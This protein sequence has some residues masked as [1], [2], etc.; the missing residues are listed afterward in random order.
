MTHLTPTS[1]E[2]EYA[3]AENGFLDLFTFIQ[4]Q[5]KPD[6]STRTTMPGTFPDSDIPPNTFNANGQH[7]LLQEQNAMPSTLSGAGV[8]RLGA[9]PHTEFSAAQNFRHIL[10][11]AKVRLNS[12]YN[13]V[14]ST[15]DICGNLRMPQLDNGQLADINDYVN[16][17]HRT[18]QEIQDLLENIRPDVDIPKEDREGTPEGLKYALYEH[19]KLALTWLKQMEEGTNKGGILADDIGLGKTISALA[20]ILSR[21][22]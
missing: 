19:Q 4:T 1:S 18:T 15:S 3:S 2:Q 13:G 10:N 5:T 22:L 7:V 9:E 17:P 8:V 11:Q 16:N 6:C 14:V 12:L 21:P 20:L